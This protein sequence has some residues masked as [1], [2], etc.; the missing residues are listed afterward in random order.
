MKGSR[1][2]ILGVFLVLI[3]LAGIGV[4]TIGVVLW[5]H[6]QWWRQWGWDAERPDEFLD[7]VEIGGQLVQFYTHNTWDAKAIGFLEA[8]P[9]GRPRYFPVY[10]S[11]RPIGP[12]VLKVFVSDDDKEMWVFK[13]R[14]WEDVIYHRVGSEHI[15][16]RSS[17]ESRYSSVPIPPTIGGDGGRVGGYEVVPEMD[18]E[19]VRK[20]LTLRY[21]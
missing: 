17:G 14:G 2:K 9:A 10:M 8:G 6:I 16:F 1:R 19:R 13:L 11:D 18:R 21:P 12:L 4:M 7:S 5:P 3:T 20:V 15:T